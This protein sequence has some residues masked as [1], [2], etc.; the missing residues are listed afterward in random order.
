MHMSLFNNF[1]TEIHEVFSRWICSVEVARGSGE[2]SYKIMIEATEGCNINQG[3]CA[4]RV[5]STKFADKF[6][7]LASHH[8]Q[9][10]NS[11]KLL[12][13]T[14]DQRRPYNTRIYLT[15]LEI[16]MQNGKVGKS[17]VFSKENVFIALVA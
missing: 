13:S 4:K 16:F 7:Q 6:C 2:D 15:C 14:D 8:L 9:F 12:K 3:K 10:Q 11:R 17:D 5:K 1:F